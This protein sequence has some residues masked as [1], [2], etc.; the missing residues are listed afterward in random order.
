MALSV[1]GRLFLT[2]NRKSALILWHI[3]PSLNRERFIDFRRN[4]R[5]FQGR[6]LLKMQSFTEEG[7]PIHQC[8]AFWHSTSIFDSAVTD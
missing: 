5:Q 3:N 7:W 2:R 8:Y 4:A 6:V 1:F